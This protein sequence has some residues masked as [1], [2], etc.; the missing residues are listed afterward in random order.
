MPRGYACICHGNK[1]RS[2]WFALCLALSVVAAATISII[3]NN[4]RYLYPYPWCVCECECY[5]VFRPPNPIG[6]NGVAAASAVL[7]NYVSSKNTT[8]YA[9]NMYYKEPMRFNVSVSVWILSDWVS[10]R[11]YEFIS[12]YGFV[13][14]FETT[15]LVDDV[16]WCCGCHCC[17]CWCCF[18]CF[19]CRFCYWNTLPFISLISQAI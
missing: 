12:I 5:S 1:M 16:I 7:H 17:C 6:L 10:M 8:N 13:I 18:C 9:E 15:F 3:F 11:V 19:C 4:P 2:A 14:T